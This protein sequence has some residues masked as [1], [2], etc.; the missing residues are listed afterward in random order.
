M[1]WAP[2][3]TIRR[4]IVERRNRGKDGGKEECWEK[5]NRDVK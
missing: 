5:K 3:E 2:N 1:D 4:K